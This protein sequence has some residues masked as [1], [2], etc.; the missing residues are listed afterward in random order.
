MSEPKTVKVRITATQ[1]VRYVQVVDMEERDW[2]RILAALRAKDDAEIDA[3]ADD[4]LDKH[5]VDDADRIVDAQFERVRPPRKKR[6]KA[7]AP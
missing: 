5:D 1:E 4:W 6:S 7:G 2:K 3:L